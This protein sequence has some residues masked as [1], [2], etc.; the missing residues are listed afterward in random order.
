VIFCVSRQKLASC[1][2]DLNALQGA[3]AF[4]S[5]A[6]VYR[7]GAPNPKCFTAI[8][9]MRRHLTALNSLP[10]RRRPSSNQWNALWVS[11]LHEGSDWTHE[12]R[13]DGYRAIGVKGDETILYSPNH[14]NFNRRFLADRRQSLRIGR[15]GG[16]RTRPDTPKFPRFHGVAT[17]CQIQLLILLTKPDSICTRMDFWSGRWEPTGRLSESWEAV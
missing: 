14:K 8:A 1:S 3:E 4:G 13:L 2:L 17:A 9:T 15:R 6:I 12:V 5:G 11:A 7:K 10:K 16:D